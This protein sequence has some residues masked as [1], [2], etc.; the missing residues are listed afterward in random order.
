MRVK[1][2]DAALRA[3]GLDSPLGILIQVL[4]ETGC[5]PKEVSEAH[6]SQ[7]TF[8]YDEEGHLFGGRL[9]LFKHKTYHKTATRRDV[10]LSLVAAQL[11]LD[12]KKLHGNGP[13]FPAFNGPDDICKQIEAACEAAGVSDFQSKDLRPASST[14]TSTRCPSSTCA[15]SSASPKLDREE[16]HEALR[17]AEE[18][19]G[20]KRL[21][22][23]KRYVVPNLRASM[24]ADPE[25][26]P[27][28][29]AR[30]RR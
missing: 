5:R 13:L 11:L 1:T 22:T 10:Q 14:A 4:D 23:I 7:V 8:F 2:T 18:A 16:P 30:P 12:R 3:V 21:N 19:T 25:S 26:A 20:H 15:R 29:P 28:R 9:H 17:A 6:G 27:A 24:A